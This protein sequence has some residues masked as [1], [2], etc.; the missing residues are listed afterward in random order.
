MPEELKFHFPLSTL[1]RDGDG[2]VTAAEAHAEIQARLLDN[3]ISA[4]RASAVSDTVLLAHGTVTLDTT[5]N[6]VSQTLTVTLPRAA[7]VRHA[8][9]MMRPRAS[10]PQPAPSLGRGTH[11]TRCC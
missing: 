9:Y 3:L 1:L 7:V 11:T 6:G 8:S 2:I 10:G 5:S 4:T